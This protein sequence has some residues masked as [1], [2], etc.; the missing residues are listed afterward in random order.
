MDPK[1]VESYNQIKMCMCVDV[2]GGYIRWLT[3]NSTLL[4]ENISLFWNLET[5]LQVNI[6]YLIYLF[7]F[8]WA[9]EYPLF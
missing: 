8:R 7:F 3:Y 5:T 2:C 1:R 4:L 9:S 6:S